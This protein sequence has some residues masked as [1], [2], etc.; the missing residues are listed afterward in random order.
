MVGNL[1]TNF[2]FAFSISF[3]NSRCC[4]LLRP[5]EKVTWKQFDALICLILSHILQV[6]T[7]D[8]TEYL[9][10][11]K[12]LQN[13]QSLSMSITSNKT[14]LRKSINSRYFTYSDK[15]KKLPASYSWAQRL[16]LVSHVWLPSSYFSFLFSI[17]LI[18]MKTFKIFIQWLAVPF[19][20]SVFSFFR[21][22]QSEN[23]AGQFSFKLYR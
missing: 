4:E 8:D 17:L 23:G 15:R 14:C 3:N 16:S 22:H 7:S 10:I 19:K 20:Q 1:L 9:K 18:N 11:R 2:H 12:W 6:K 21:S 5:M 13:T